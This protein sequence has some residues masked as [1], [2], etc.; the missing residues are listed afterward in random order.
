MSTIVEVAKRAGVSVGTVSNVLSGNPS[1]GRE[2]RERVEAAIRALDYHPNEIA[3]S[4]KVKQ[5]YMLG[6]VL[7]D[8]TNPFFPDIM[9]GAEE[10]ALQ[11]RYLLVTANTDEQIEREQSI[12]AALRSRRVDGILLAC[13]PGKDSGHIRRVVE[14]GIPVVCLDRAAVGIKLDSVLLDNVRGGQ[15]CVR[16]LLRVGY[17][18]IAVITGPHKLQIARERLRGYVEAHREAHLDVNRELILE[19][20]FREESGYRIAK[21]LLLR[22][23]RPSAIFVCNGMMTLGVL[24]AFEE[25]GVHYP[26]DLGLAT[27]DDIVGDHSFYPRLTVVAQPT[28]EMGA[29]GAD[30]LMDRIDGKLKGKPLIVRLKPTLTVRSSTKTQNPVAVSS[31]RPAAL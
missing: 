20:D 12:L 29:Q 9:R 11:R 4:L 15:D 30:L 31:L 19:G 22:R 17:R 6:M 16:H 10:K 2:L 27:F 14:A 23:V 21:E 26:E 1:V 13:A 8:I 18:N 28:Y 7:P 5:T 3:R 24:Q 25:M